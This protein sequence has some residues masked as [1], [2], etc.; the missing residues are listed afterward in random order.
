MI[1]GR[2]VVE[3]VVAR[4]DGRDYGFPVEDVVEVIAMIS[5][6]PVPESPAWLLGVADVRGRMVPVVDLRARLGLRSLPIGLTTPI[7]IVRR[8]DRWLGLVVDAVDEVLSLPAEAVDD[9]DDLVE[10]SVVAGI[11]RWHARIVVVLEI[12]PLFSAAAIYPVPG[13]G[14]RA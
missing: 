8:D 14:A 5:L 2:E 11:A 12:A 7:L 10:S 13:A 3:L 4:I 1:D 6:A 9:M